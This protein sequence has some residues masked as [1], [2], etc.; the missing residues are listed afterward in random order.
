MDTASNAWNGARNVA[1]GVG[2][3]VGNTASS[4]SLEYLDTERKRIAERQASLVA[5]LHDRIFGAEKERD[6]L[7]EVWDTHMFEIYPVYL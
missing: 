3:A 1:S 7:M 4:N 6:P 5:K 2:Q